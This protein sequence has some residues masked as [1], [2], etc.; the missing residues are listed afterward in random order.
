MRR[1]QFANRRDRN[2]GESASRRLSTRGTRHQRAVSALHTS[3]S[4]A[5]IL[6]A[7]FATASL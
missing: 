6:I 7:I 1:C 2:D 5:A 4:G 3:P